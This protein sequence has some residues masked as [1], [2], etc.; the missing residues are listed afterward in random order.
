MTQ[1]RNSDSLYTIPQAAEILGVSSQRVLELID[2]DELE[3]W[4]AS[5]G[6]IPNTSESKILRWRITES[7]LQKYR[8]RQRERHSSVEHR[9][10]AGARLNHQVA[11]RA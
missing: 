8:E 1:T 3:A 6:P 2:L 9:A 4:C 7:S 5:I 10:T 11:R